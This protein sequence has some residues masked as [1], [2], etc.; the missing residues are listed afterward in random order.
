MVE[1]KVVPTGTVTISDFHRII[2]AERIHA[3]DII[4]ISTQVRVRVSLSSAISS[5]VILYYDKK[6]M[7]RNE[8]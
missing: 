5:D 7:K 8:T 2:V 6:R 3:N 1:R 4:K